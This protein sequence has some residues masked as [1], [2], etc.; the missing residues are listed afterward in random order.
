MNKETSHRGPDGTGVYTDQHV[1]LGHNRLSIIDLRSVAGQP[2]VSHDGRFVIVF[3]GEIYNYLE[4]KQELKEGYSFATA[5]D[6][7]VLLAAY[8][9]WGKGMLEK[10]NGIFAFAI[11]D[12]KEHSLM[13]ARDPVGVKPL[14]YHLKDGRLFFS[15]EVKALLTCGASRQ[16]DMDAL[17]LYFRIMYVPGPQTIFQ[18]IK[19]LMPGH[20]AVW[21]D[22]EMV[23]ERYAKIDKKTRTWDKKSDLKD[24]VRSAVQRSVERQLVSDKPL[25]IFL[26]GGVDSSAVL[27]CVSK[28]R[29]NIDTFS[30]GF[31]LPKKSDREKF[32]HDVDIAE[33]TARHY[34]TNH[35]TMTIDAQYVASNFERIIWHL[36]EP[37]SNPTIVS[38]YALSQYTKDFVTVVLGGDGGDELFGGYYRYHFSYLATIYQRIPQLVRSVMNKHPKIRKLDTDAGIDRFTLFMFQKDPVL[39]EVLKKSDLHASQI[40][41]HFFSE[42]YFKNQD[43][44]PFESQFMDVDLQTWLVDESLMRTDKMS[45]AAGL[46]TRVPFL[47][48]E[49]IALAYQIPLKYKIS[50]FDKK[51]ILKEAFAEELPSYVVKQP[52]RGW[53]SPGAKWLRN[54]AMQMFVR[55]VLSSSYNEQ[56]SAM[57]D[58][59][60]VSKMLDDHIDGSRYNLTMIWALLTFQVWARTYKVTFSV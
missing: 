12:K 37:I 28:V 33:R 16:V 19:K 30:M 49:L 15:S 8:A 24:A 53:I 7:E 4:L 1:T 20:A 50:L 34:G 31:D 56:T 27:N 6:T 14:Y 11:W 38:T 23:I 48:K 51:K 55:E 29:D 22:G 52:K 42:K 44:R 5:S 2:M 41:Y 54:P 17:A 45:M 39:R 36:D 57:F 59:G 25:G 40:P 47:D 35:H 21:K 3:N 32:N 10:L 13:I 46:E 60:V 26:S 18:S 58:W 43:K 9:K